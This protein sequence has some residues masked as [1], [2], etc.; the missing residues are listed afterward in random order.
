MLSNSS[1]YA[2]A[3]HDTVVDKKPLSYLDDFPKK[4]LKL[5]TA[6]VNKALKKYLLEDKLSSAAAGTF[7]K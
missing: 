4:I 6:D 5:K 7:K 1:A 3:A 2:R